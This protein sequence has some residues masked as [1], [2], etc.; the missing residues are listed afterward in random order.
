MGGT[1]VVQVVY[2]NYRRYSSADVH[3]IPF[4]SATAAKSL[5]MSLGD[6]FLPIG[7]VLT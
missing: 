3:Y 7:I 4:C 5:S 6:D 2:G 1:V